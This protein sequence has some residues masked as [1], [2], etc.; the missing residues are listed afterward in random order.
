[1]KFE[2]KPTDITP[3]VLIPIPRLPGGIVPFP[4]GTGVPS[5]L[6]GGIPPQ[7]VPTPQTNAPLIGVRGGTGLP[8][9]PLPRTIPPTTPQPR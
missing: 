3:A 1:L 6:P 8:G 4:P 9:L 5:G 7:P 2:D